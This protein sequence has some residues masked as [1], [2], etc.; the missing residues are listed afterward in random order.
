[1]SSSAV[2]KSIV[3]S[4]TAE[5]KHRET[6]NNMSDTDPAKDELTDTD[7]AKDELTDTD[8]AKDEL[9]DTGPA[10]LAVR[11]QLMW[12][13]MS[14]GWVTTGNPQLCDTSVIQAHGML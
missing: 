5:E 3:T 1:M 6:K 10:N 14:P 7:P 8:P 4:A 9:T 13:E 12:C 2:D 11:E